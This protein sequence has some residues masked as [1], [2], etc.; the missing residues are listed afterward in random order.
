VFTAALYAPHYDT[1]EDILLAL[2]LLLIMLDAQAIHQ[3][4]TNLLATGALDSR[5]KFI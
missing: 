3:A 5:S 1:Y 4:L 2:K